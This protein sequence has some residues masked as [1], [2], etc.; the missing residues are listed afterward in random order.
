MAKILIAEDERDIR[1]LVVFTLELLGG[2][3]VIQAEN[4]EQALEMARREQP[5]VIMLDL[6]MPRMG[7]LEACRRLKA[8]PELAHIPVIILSARGLDDEVQAGLDAGASLYMVKPFDTGQ[9]VTDV[10]QFLARA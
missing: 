6:R 7:G 9:L 4:G 8:S 10:D 5:D 2:H 3:T 1:E